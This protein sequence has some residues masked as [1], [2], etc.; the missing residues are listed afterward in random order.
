[1][2]EF[3][4]LC[5]QKLLSQIKITAKLKKYDKNDTFKATARP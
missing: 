1:M 2:K 3:S 4:L 5:L